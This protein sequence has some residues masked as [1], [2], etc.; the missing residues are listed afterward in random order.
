MEKTFKDFYKFP[1]HVSDVLPFKT[2][3]ADSRAMAYDV[4][5]WKL[6]PNVYQE[7]IDIINGVRKVNDSEFW[8]KPAFYISEGCK[9]YNAEEPSHPLI[10]V[11]GWGRLTGHGVKGEK[12]PEGVAKQIQDDFTHYIVKKLNN[13]KKEKK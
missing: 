10:I 7:L 3:C 11:R 4:T 1:L 5:N 9:I 6:E 13:R 8:G 2:F 12:L